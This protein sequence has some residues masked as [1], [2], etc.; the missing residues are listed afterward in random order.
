MLVL[1]GRLTCPRPSRAFLSIP[2]C[3]ALLA[4]AAA[5]VR[6]RIFFLYGATR[7]EL[8]NHEQS[9]SLAAWS[10]IELSTA[11]AAV[12]FLLLALSADALIPCLYKRRPIS[13]GTIHRISIQ[14]TDMPSH[15]SR[16]SSTTV[17][18]RPD[19]AYYPRQSRFHDDISNLDFDIETPASRLSNPTILSQDAWHHTRNTST[20]SRFSGFTYS[21][22]T[23]EPRDVP[24]RSLMEMGEIIQEMA[25]REDCPEIYDM[26]NE[27]ATLGGHC[28][29]MDGAIEHEIVVR[30]HS[31]SLKGSDGTEGKESET[32]SLTSSNDDSESALSFIDIPR[33]RYSRVRFSSHLE[34][35]LSLRQN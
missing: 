34:N 16:Y 6:T 19:T 8:P 13:V 26:R 30:T 2:L 33:R 31:T 21:A 15:N 11:L 4:C 24:D 9:T 35:S 10:I 22:S 23:I 17:I 12:N 25:M 1:A 3:F 20:W 7:S 32:T 27:K 29:N 14:P 28:A 18:Y 5:V